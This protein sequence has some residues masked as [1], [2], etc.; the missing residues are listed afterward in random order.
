MAPG[1]TISRSAARTATR[2]LRLQSHPSLQ[3][4]GF[5]SI[6]LPVYPTPDSGT[7]RVQLA[8]GSVRLDGRFH[9]DGKQLPLLAGPARPLPL[10]PACA[11]LFPLT[12]GFRSDPNEFVTIGTRSFASG[13]RLYAAFA[14]SASPAACSGAASS[15]DGGSGAGG[16]TQQSLADEMIAFAHSCLAR[17]GSDA[18]AVQEGL[19][20]VEHG[21]TMLKAQEGQA[22]ASQAARLLKFK[23]A[24]HMRMHD[25]P[26][27]VEALEEVAEL[28]DAGLCERVGALEEV[29]RIHLSGHADANAMESAREAATLLQPLAPPPA[30]QVG[31]DSAAA[32]AAAVLSSPSP[33]GLAALR[34]RVL[35]SVGLVEQLCGHTATAREHFQEADELEPPDCNAV[36]ATGLARLAMAMHLHSVG[37]WEQATSYYSQLIQNYSSLP[38][39]TSPIPSSTSSS[40]PTNSP[41]PASSVSPSHSPSLDPAAAVRVGALAGQG[42]L[43]LLQGKFDAAEES[44]TAALREAEAIDDRSDFNPVVG[45]ILSLLGDT[46]AQRGRLQ[47]SGEGMIAEGLFRRSLAL[48]EAS[49]W[50]NLDYR[51]T[52][53]AGAGASASAEGTE[54]E[55][56]Q[57]KDRKNRVLQ[58]DLI[59]FTLE[60]Y[61]AALPAFPMRAS[62]A[63]SMSAAAHH[64][65]RS[66]LSLHAAVA[67]SRVPATATSSSSHGSATTSAA[68]PVDALASFPA[69]VVDVTTGRVLL[70]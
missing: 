22:A 54:E 14:G 69:A 50:D 63:Q 53:L 20:V 23:A 37:Q 29:V 70:S 4:P 40:S 64:L 46:Y 28:G 16:G 47:H 51:L 8:D 41:S 2:L 43:L 59:A 7:D 61:A 36:P 68:S 38:S 58:L 32:S 34:Y 67:S 18:T 49:Q 30:T 52:L 26:G 65:W 19:R 15:G 25:N 45:A 62:E 21:A 5:A 12:S 6:L 17:E 42:Q 48:L 1:A 24:L 10:L 66:P 9:P 60:R 35:C 39:S 44:F 31:P 13:A 57:L 3:S 11:A 55:A 27:A 56:D 33:P